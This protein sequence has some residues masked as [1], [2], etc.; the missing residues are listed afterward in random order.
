MGTLQKF[1]VTTRTDLSAEFLHKTKYEDDALEILEEK[2]T[3]LHGEQL[4]ITRDSASVFTPRKV[5]S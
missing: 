4:K 2:A 5:Q 1:L 3:R